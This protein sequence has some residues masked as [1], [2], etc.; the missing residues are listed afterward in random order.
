MRYL[1]SYTRSRIQ[2]V[3]DTSLARSRIRGDYVTKLKSYVEIPAFD[4]ANIWRGASQVLIRYDFAVGVSSLL[5]AFPITPPAGVNFV[6]VVSW[7]KDEV[8]Y[9]YKLWEDVGEILWLP[10]YNKEKITAEDFFSIEIWNTDTRD[11]YAL[12]A[13]DDTALSPGISLGF[14]PEANLLL[15]NAIRL[16]TSKLIIPTTL[17]QNEEILLLNPTECVDPRFELSD[18]EPIFGD[19]Y[20]LVSPCTRQ[21]IKG[22]KHEP[23]VGYN[24]LKSTDDTWHYV[25]FITFE[26]NVTYEV[27]QANTVPPPDALGYFA[28]IPVIE[29]NAVYKLALYA[30]PNSDGSVTHTLDIQGALSSSEATRA[31]VVLLENLTDS[32]KYGLFLSGSTID[33]LS[34]NVY[35]H[36]ITL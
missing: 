9:R 27:D 16:Y 29:P 32:L 15:A 19:Y 22:I 14:G 4:L 23:A 11:E 12:S 5:N 36:P 20:L 1:S 18:F 6:P 8:Y 33:T 21:L 7:L 24:I 13:G 2:G 30:I 25:W 34:I 10:L 28:M 17:C 26:G 3:K 31:N 35:P